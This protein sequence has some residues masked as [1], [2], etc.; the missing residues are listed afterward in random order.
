MCK[1]RSLNLWV[2]VWPILSRSIFLVCVHVL[3]IIIILFYKDLIFKN[4]NKDFLLIISNYYDP[5]IWYFYEHKRD[6]V[7]EK[8]LFQTHM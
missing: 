4:K 5:K 1:I 6:T 7:S 8:L 3:F 2:F